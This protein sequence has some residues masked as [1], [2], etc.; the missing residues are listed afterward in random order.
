MSTLK[1]DT[2]Q[3][4]SGGAATLTKQQAAKQWA[5]LNGDG[6]IA[7]RDSFN[8]STATDNGTGDYS[9]TFTNSMSDANY[10]VVGAISQDYGNS[11]DIF[12]PHTDSSG[13]ASPSSSTYRNATRNNSGTLNNNPRVNAEVQG[14]LA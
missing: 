4:T 14:D 2:I 5:N 11:N 3:N 8:T 13:E 9:F 6:T 12:Q 10:L 7:L 1:A